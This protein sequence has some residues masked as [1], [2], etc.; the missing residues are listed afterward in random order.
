[1]EGFFC[2]MKYIEDADLR[3]M[4][5]YVKI[6]VSAVG[7]STSNKVLYTERVTEFDVQLVSDIKVETKF[8][9][10][11]KLNKDQ[12]SQSIIVFSSS[13]FKV[14][15]DYGV[16]EESQLVLHK[17][18]QMGQNWNQYN[19][20]VQIPNQ[21]SH[22]FDVDVVLSHD[23]A[24]KPKRIKLGFS[25]AAS[26]NPVKEKPKVEVKHE[27]EDEFP[28]SSLFGGSSKQEFNSD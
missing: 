18:E 22:S 25:D 19:L 24:Q 28:D 15:F 1:M 6:T 9:S 3:A 12:R 10:G 4:P 14:N 7:M 23:F 20:T 2:V 16:P 11:V 26:Q 17:V 8:Q 5:K 27:E 13:D 21:V